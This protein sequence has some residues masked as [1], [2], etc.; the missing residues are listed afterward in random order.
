MTDQSRGPARA[1][2]RDH[3]Q[4]RTAFFV[5]DSTGVT[6]ETLGSALLVNFPGIV[7]TRHTIPF[8]NN[9]GYGF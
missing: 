5:S 6:A 4:T 2:V 9:D 7:F 8:A 3:R 1:A